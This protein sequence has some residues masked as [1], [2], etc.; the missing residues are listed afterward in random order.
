MKLSR[1]IMALTMCVL[2]IAVVAVSAM[3]AFGMFQVLRHQAEVQLRTIGEAKKAA[4]VRYHDGLLKDVEVLANSVLMAEATLEFDVAWS[5]MDSEARLALQSS[6]ADDGFYLA[7]END[8]GADGQGGVGYREAHSRYH[9]TL[10]EVLQGHDFNDLILLNGDGILVYSTSKNADFGVNVTKATWRDTD[11]AKAF[12]QIKA[13]ASGDGPLFLDYRRYRGASDAVVGFIA[14]PIVIDEAFRGVLAYQI[15]PDALNM[16][17]APPPALAKSGEVIVVG[18]DFMVR[19]DTAFTK[20]APLMRRL[21]NAA[22][23]LAL[24][25]GAGLVTTESSAGYHLA[26]A[27]PVDISGQSFALVVSQP[28][29]AFLLPFENLGLSVGFGFAIVLSGLLV[30]T[31]IAARRIARPIEQIAKSQ[32]QLAEGD[33]NVSSPGL[34]NPSEAAD[35]SEA[36]YVFRKQARNAERNRAIGEA[37]KPTKDISNPIDQLTGEYE[38]NL[39]TAIESISD[40]IPRLSKKSVDVGEGVTRLSSQTG[41]A[42]DRARQVR[43][44]VGSLAASAETANSAFDDVAEKLDETSGLSN[45]AAR[46]A[47]DVSVKMTELT[48]ASEQ[49]EELTV[50]ISELASRTN[51]V[52]L[53]AS[54][55]AVRAGADG[56][57][58]GLIAG[59]IRSIAAQ[60]QRVA[61]NT[62]RQNADLRVEMDETSTAIRMVSDTVNHTNNTVAGIEGAVALQVVA[63]GNVARAARDAS[64]MVQSLVDDLNTVADD[65]QTTDTASADLRSTAEILAQTGGDLV[66]EVSKLL[67][68]IKSRSGSAKS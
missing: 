46:Q 47:A 61:E 10:L 26:Y 22:V 56:K 19:N 6:Y 13:N 43:I 21:D 20:D 27:L 4:F 14:A 32:K 28:V 18:D 25:G 2:L 62:R 50:V 60:I 12:R 34:T 1:Q 7:A 17:M 42:R 36:M 9:P 16:L 37:E 40:S 30:V 39:T 64:T 58:F 31:V 59:E 45:S 51:I 29:E 33:T 23:Q 24:S 53:N 55:E 8:L 66:N 57:G 11:L 54:L 35:L 48:H 52:S 38:T 65:A 41:S 5:S 3:A 49:L 63:T 67:A 68:D 44:D 15:R